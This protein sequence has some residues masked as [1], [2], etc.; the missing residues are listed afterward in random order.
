MTAT[1]HKSDFELTT[2]TPYLALVG[3]LC[4][5]YYENFEENCVITAPHYIFLASVAFLCRFS[6]EPKK[7]MNIYNLIT[8]Q[9]VELNLKDEQG[10][11]MILISTCTWICSWLF[12]WWYHNAMQFKINTHFKPTFQTN[13]E[14]WKYLHHHY[15]DIL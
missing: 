9:I 2:D 3:E 7:I 13:M 4:G 10:T 12:V 11:V 14:I 5:V 1:E 8:I 15:A 6:N